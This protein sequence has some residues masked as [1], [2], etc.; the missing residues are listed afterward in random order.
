MSRT[1]FIF[2]GILYYV[3]TV[4]LIIVV[5]QEQ[6]VTRRPNTTGLYTSKEMLSTACFPT[7]LFE[8]ISNFSPIFIPFLNHL[9]VFL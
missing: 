2:I 7:N 1:T 9:S 6:F 5:L 4:I 8:T 3:F